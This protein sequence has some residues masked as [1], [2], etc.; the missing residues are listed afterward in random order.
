MDEH[1]IHQI[2]QQFTS[3]GWPQFLNRV[4]I[5]G[6]RSWEGSV[7]DFRFP[8]VAIVGEN[9]TGKSTLLKSAACAY[10]NDDV[11]KRFDP[12]DF[13][14]QTFWD[15]IEGVSLE[16][17]ITRGPNS[18]DYRI[19]KPSKRWRKQI[20][21]PKRNVYLLDISRTLPID[22]SVG[23]AKIARLASGEI[24]SNV[25][26]DD[27]RIKL[28]H[29]LGRDYNVARFAVS[30]VDRG[31]NVGLLTSG[32]AEISQYHQ[33]AGE[34]AT[35]DT[36]LILEGLPNNS[37]LIIDEVEASLHPKAQRRLVRFLLWLCRQK[38]IQV[39]LSTHSPY[40]LNELPKD[41]R[42]LLM[43]SPQGVNVIQ[44]VSTELAMSAL[45]D[46]VHSE[47]DVYVEDNSAHVWLREILAS[48]EESSPLLQRISIYPVGA[49]NVVKT[50]GKL[51]VDEKL[52]RKGLGVVDGD[53]RDE[54]CSYLPG[55]VAPERFVY[56]Q[57]R[58]SQWAELPERFG[59][60]A[61]TLFTVL[62]DVMRE[63]NHHKWNTLVGDRIRKSSQSVWETMVDEW[64]KVCLTDGERQR[65]VEDINV[66]LNR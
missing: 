3:N 45:D 41:A 42:I 62:E 18:N 50:M 11:S 16:Y 47:L 52:P 66:A 38:K 53:H 60:G 37:L 56:S 26:S 7:V 36:F 55:E 25:L 58:D 1:E 59:V 65:L 17:N 44:G 13:F 15:T 32:G 5:N 22:A 20:N 2:R 9:G 34:D 27:Y 35:L 39:I 33:G 63:P 28:S 14:L 48:N 64:C 29:V 43:P 8:I 12:S 6:L 23:Y 49:A 24:S 31:R 51:A 10:D 4:K 30:D 46:E 40:V 57:L 54:I 21:Q 61:G 19:T